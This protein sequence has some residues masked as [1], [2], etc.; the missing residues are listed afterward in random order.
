[1]K[2][3]SHNP[4]LVAR[5]KYTINLTSRWI[6]SRITFLFIGLSSLL[7]IAQETDKAPLNSAFVKYTQSKNNR[8]ART[9]SGHKL[10]YI[11]SPVKADFS[12]F[13]YTNSNRQNL[14]SVFDMRVNGTITSVKD[15]GDCGSC[16][17]F[18][19]MGAVESR[20][21][22]L[23]HGTFDLSEDNLKNCH[24]FDFPPCDGGN[25]TMGTAYFARRKGPLLETQDPYSAHSTQ[26]CPSGLTPTGI[27]SEALFFPRDINAMKQAIMDYGALYHAFYWDDI[28][29]RDRDNTYY[30]DTNRTDENNHATLIVGWNDSIPTKA[31]LGAWIIKNS[32]ADDWGDHGFFYMAYQDKS[33]FEEVTCYKTREDYNPLEVVYG[34]DDLGWVTEI[35]G[36][37]ISYGAIKFIASGDQKINSVSTYAVS[38]NAKITVELYDNF[39][40]STFSGL[41]ASIPTKTFK[42]AGY[43]N[44]KFA[45]PPSIASGNDFFVRIK[46]QTANNYYPI[47]VEEA[48]PDYASAAVIENNVCW[49]S[50]TGT[51][52]KKMGASTSMPDDL[53]IKVIAESKCMSVVATASNVNVNAC[54]NQTSNIDVTTNNNVSSNTYKWQVLTSGSTTWT[55]ITNNRVYANATTPSL[56][57]TN[58]PLTLSNNLYRCVVT[59]ACNS[60]TSAPITLNVLSQV[61]ITAQPSD[62]SKVEGSRATFKVILSST[63]N[64]NVVYQ[65]Q[66]STN[67][68]RWSNISNS[69]TYSGTQTA[70]LKV[71]AKMALNNYQ[72]RCK[73]NSTCDTRALYTNI[74]KLTVLPALSIQ[75]QEGN[76][77]DEVIYTQPEED[78]LG[79]VATINSVYPNPTKGDINLILELKK[80]NTIDISVY[81]ILG[82]K[83]Y[84]IYS[85]EKEEGIHYINADLNHLN[86]GMYFI[87]VVVN[88]ELTSQS[89]KVSILK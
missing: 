36:S 12:E 70:T 28:Y 23:G 44:L 67:G 29:F 13:N 31:G 21:K 56:Q 61:A 84:S 81:N 64:L 1:M 14:P 5:G 72:Y 49:Y 54:A 34:Y 86:S 46:Y 85:G 48:L 73:I 57:I 27:V 76:E 69:T 22:I 24:G 18:P 77:V 10:G 43:Y 55:T 52:W 51:T 32:W 39:N 88:N 37:T 9:S 41:L 65:W 71:L 16:W 15:Q 79:A 63:A 78:V 38:A 26:T 20:W 80:L 82:A 4:V 25:F 40:G 33:A 19:T 6:V 8:A 83:V 2:N 50:Q 7:V 87:R 53:C 3:T 17:L 66:C 45:T 68:T 89:Y 42:E 47:P 59:S 62:Q 35:G 58:T 11:P 60:S 30:C 75:Q 74:A